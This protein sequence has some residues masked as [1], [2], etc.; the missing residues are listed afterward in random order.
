MKYLLLIQ[1]GPVQG[2]IASARRTRDLRGGSQL[3]SE[4][5]KLA[6]HTI[7]ESEEEIDA[8][9]F[10]APEDLND[11]FP[12]TPL[13][14]ANKIV[15]R[16]S[17]DPQ[18]LCQQVKRNIATFLLQTFD[19]IYTRSGMPLHLDH[20]VA[21]AQIRDLVEFTW[22][23]VPYTEAYGVVRKRAEL[24][25]S[26]RKQ[27]RL[28]QAVTWGSPMH[29]S[30]LTGQLE[31][32]YQ[33]PGNLTEQEWNRLAYDSYHAG[34]AEYLSGV[35]LLK[36]RGQFMKQPP[37]QPEAIISTSH[38]AALPFLAHLRPLAH[39]AQ[40]LDAWQ[41]YRTAARNLIAEPFDKLPKDMPVPVLGHDDGALLYPERLLEKMDESR[42]KKAAAQRFAPVQALL[43]RFL[44]VVN[45]QAENT[46]PLSPYYAI[47]LADGDNMGKVIQGLA[48]HTDT[49]E[50]LHRQLSRA[51]DEFAREAKK[52]VE[53]HQGLPIYAGGDDV[54][55]LVPLHTMCSCAQQLS[56]TFR[57]KLRAFDTMPDTPPTLS[58]GLAVVHHLSLLQD[59]LDT[60]RRAEKQAKSFPRKNAL[61]LVIQKRSGDIYSIVGQWSH[62]P[63]KKAGLDAYLQE[64]IGY[65]QRDLLPHG[66][67][68]ELRTSLQRLEASSSLTTDREE[69]AALEQAFQPIQ[70]TEAKRIL[71]RKL[72]LP[73][74]RLASGK[75]EK[76]AW[77]SEAEH[78]LKR[79]LSRMKGGEQDPDVETEP[80]LQPVERLSLAQF[81]DALII[82]Q[83]LADMIG[84][85]VP[86][87]R[88]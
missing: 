15:A 10:P 61:A 7:V 38:I 79:L 4:V 37:D 73:Q 78:L 2:F 86:K 35:D 18:G 54:L 49:G 55:A 87:E 25:L 42:E 44:H 48:G 45:R 1:I 57:Q 6:A 51:L 60:A 70:Y 40:I 74:S 56:R 32:V 53:D 52:I 9:I 85:P 19:A 46:I 66:A 88:S 80:G 50:Q 34:P 64:F 75:Q 22:V 39:N 17:G 27:T 30:S 84:P 58:V 23:A 3:L 13:N 76:A 77:K 59:A 28:Y 5:S 41:Q 69:R 83:E 11:L 72:L 21:R 12:G 47:L 33:K 71:T 82:A 43:Q 31:S 24:L 8:L 20:E 62:N 16:V 63:Q 81:I 68:Y 67:A 36:R 29:K 14:V 65:F 26:A